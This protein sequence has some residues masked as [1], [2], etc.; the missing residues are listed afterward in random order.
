[1]IPSNACVIFDMDGTLINSKAVLT[2]SLQYAVAKFGIDVENPDT[3]THLLGPPLRY[4]MQS[5]FKLSKEDADTATDIFHEH[6]AATGMKKEEPFIGIYETLDT[7]KKRGHV[8]GVA[9]AAPQDFAEE[10]LAHHELAQYFSAIAGSSPSRRDKAIIIEYCLEQ[11]VG[12]GIEHGEPIIMI[13]DRDRD[14]TAA[15][16]LGIR[17]I[18]A[19]YG[20]ASPGE[21]KN[22]GADHLIESHSDLIA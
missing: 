5:Y 22:A 9:T 7:L 18:G 11:F 20:Y 8:L 1:M 17:S 21:L 14:I 10:I 2:K 3:L 19:E 15:K 12:Q 4:T 13:G 16:E 6:Y